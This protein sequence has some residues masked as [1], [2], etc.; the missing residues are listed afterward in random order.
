MAAPLGLELG[1]FHVGAKQIER[2]AANQLCDERPRLAGRADPV[3]ERQLVQRRP[4]GQIR[5]R[6]QALD[7]QRALDHDAVQFGDEA[8]AR[9]DSA[10]ADGKRQKLHQ[11]MPDPATI[12]GV[13][14]F[15]PGVGEDGDG[16]AS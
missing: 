4:F 12:V 13:E 2:A 16:V 1:A 10:V 7:R 5:E 8:S 15:D 6:K 3:V 9:V 14:A 11:L